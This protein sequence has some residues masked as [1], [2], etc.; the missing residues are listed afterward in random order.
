MNVVE[1]LRMPGIDDL[2][3]SK[4]RLYLGEGTPVPVVIMANVVV[5]EDDWIGPFVGC[6]EIL[7]V[8]VDN[9]L[10]AVGIER[11]NEDDDDVMQDGADSRRVAGG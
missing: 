4:T 10:F 3:N 8:P 9:E 6:A 7:F 11:R 1:N 5:P 2:L